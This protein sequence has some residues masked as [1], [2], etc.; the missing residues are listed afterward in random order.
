LTLETDLPDQYAYEV[1]VFD[2]ERGRRLVAAVEIVSPGNKD[3]PESRRALVAK[4]AALLQQGV[5]VAFVDLV[6]A[7]HFNLYADLL[8]LIGR[9]DPALG[10]K[11]P[12][13]YAATCRGRTADHRPLLD[14]WYAPLT[15]GCPLPGLPLWL[16]DD[17][18]VTL[19]LESSY[20]ETCR[21]L[22][23]A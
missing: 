18:S 17:I 22:R 8:A 16:T 15:V 7:R 13:T 21:V 6:T 19:D 3:R 14:V 5:C 11:P 20:E 2:R 1:R 4:V 23:I 9:T 12:T 10:E